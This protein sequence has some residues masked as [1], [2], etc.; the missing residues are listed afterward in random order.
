MD[1]ENPSS[2]FELYPDDGLSMLPKMPGGNA[3][4]GYGLKLQR[5]TN[6]TR[7]A[8]CGRSLVDDYF[9]WLLLSVDHVIPAAEGKRMG[10]PNDWVESYSNI[11][12]C[13]LG[14]NGF[15]NRYQIPVGEL[16]EIWTVATFC[17]LRNRVFSDRKARILIRMAAEIQFFESKPWSQ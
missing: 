10:I 11:V 12:L 8:Y 16:P 13:C 17:Q 7:C 9:H 3:R 1:L 4:H 5:L 15:G 2:P 14:C 6:Q